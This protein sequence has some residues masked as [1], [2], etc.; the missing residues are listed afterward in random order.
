MNTRDMR[1][2]YS[3]RGLAEADVAS[4]PIVQFTQWFDTARESGLIEPNA[5]ILATC[6]GDGRPSARAVLLKGYDERGF[7]FYSNYE[8]RKG[9]ELDAHPF[10]AL[11]FYWDA[12]ERQVR[13]E[14][15]VERVS[16]EESN[17]Y[18]AARPRGSQ[19]GAAA[20]PQS[21][22]V[23]SR[24]ALEARLAQLETLYAGRAV[25]RP[26]SW[27]GYCVVPEAVEFWQGRPNRLHDRLRYRRQGGGH[28]VIE[29]LAP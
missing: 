7:V 15:R 3:Q 9:H 29:R 28:W 11:V 10:A 18:F 5:M 2:E 12:L 25:P 24:E 23:P 1:R 27:G 4:D 17:Q 26:T 20:S 21:Q 16:A 13:I 19:L 8:S 6:D 22:I 14:G